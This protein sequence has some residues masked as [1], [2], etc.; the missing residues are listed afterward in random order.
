MTKLKKIS[1]VIIGTI[2]LGFGVS[3]YKL[4]SLGQDPLSAMVYAIMYLCKIEHLS[5]MFWYI[6]INLIF[7]II[8]F[9]FLRNKMHIGTIINLILT[10]VC[11]DLFY[12]LFI[13]LNWYSNSLI[14]KIIYGL[15]GL[16][17]VSMGIALYG[18]ANLGIAP[19]DAMPKI[20]ANK[21]KKIKYKYAR[22]MIDLFCTIIALLI[23]VIILRRNDIIN[24]NTILNFIFM[25]P[26]IAF[27][28]KIFSKYFYQS[29]EV[30]FS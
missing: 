13:F 7:L 22:I 25:G 26:L 9:I 29:Q 2:L 19:Y 17:I 15:L 12:R 24:I 28:S 8:M 27:F 18:S 11:S 5:Y 14:L 6:I 3:L 23:G 4:S 16:I 10:G 21:F 20:I 30:E 1:G